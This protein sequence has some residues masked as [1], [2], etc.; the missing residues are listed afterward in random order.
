MG[1]RRRWF[2]RRGGFLERR[3]LKLAGQIFNGRDDARGRTIHRITDYRKMT[4]AH[5]FKNA[6][7]RTIG[8][9]FKFV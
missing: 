2:F 6:P 9:D 7:A 4:L 3:R 8:E 5:G 1:R